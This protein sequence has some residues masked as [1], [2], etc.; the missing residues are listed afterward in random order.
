MAVEG[1]NFTQ[2]T[3]VNSLGGEE[4]LLC[5]DDDG[6][7]KTFKA[8]VLKNFIQ[9]ADEAQEYIS[10]KDDKDVK[11]RLYLKNDKLVAIKEEAFTATAPSSGDNQ[12]YDG[13]IIN[14]MYGTGSDINV[15][16]PVSHSFIE[17]YN[18]ND[19]EIN[20]KGLYLWYRA[21]SGTW[22]SLALSGI[23]PPKH[24]FLIRGKQHMNPYADTVTLPILNYDMEWDMDFSNQ[25]FSV[26]LC[27]GSE[28]PEDNPVRQIKDVSGNVTST[29][30][31]YIDLLGAGGKNEGETVIAYETRYLSCMDKNTG[32]HRIDYANSGTKNIG[33]NAL[34]SGNNEAD[35]EPIE[36][37]N[38]DV[39][40]YKPRCLADG[41]WTEFYDKDKQTETSPSM[42]NISYG[43]NGDTERCFCFHTPINKEGF[44]YYR[45]E[46][47]S[48]WN[49]KSTDISIVKD[50]ES[51]SSVHKVKLTDLTVGTYEY[52]VGYDGCWS[53][54]ATFEVKNYSKEYSNI[55]IM[56]TSDQQ[57][58]TINE[59]KVWKVMAEFLRKDNNYKNF[60]FHLNTGDISQNANRRSNKLPI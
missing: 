4:L 17:L 26:Y 56:W 45:K 24:S 51:M 13:L 33:S 41:R 27:I 50:A 43:E 21:K 28:T 14:S 15:E 7:N 22:K 18:Y 47:E 20:L 44:V 36:Y 38:C 53:D 6:V 42:I 35:C 57:S 39:D 10:V 55:N 32:I 25:G 46:G 34:V 30:G 60:D 11:Y 49:T 23:I 54:I 19:L 16:T 2:L 5:L 1:K 12:L 31:R 40:K 59:M 8:N 48:L 9:G 37:N 3:S 58:W 52:K 29:N